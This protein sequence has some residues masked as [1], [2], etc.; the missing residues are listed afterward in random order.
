MKL[1]SLCSESDHLDLL[2]ERVCIFKDDTITSE[3]EKVDSSLDT[4][5]V[6]QRGEILRRI[7]K[8]PCHGDGSAAVG[9][10]GGISSSVESN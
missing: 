3:Q 2:V 1:A 8:V 9:P 4:L 6:S 10:R 5:R 7:E